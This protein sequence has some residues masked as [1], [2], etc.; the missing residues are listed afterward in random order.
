MR[1][2]V[3]QSSYQGSESM[4]KGLDTDLP[5]PGAFTS[6]HT[7]ENRFIRKDTAKEEIDSCVKEGFDFYLNFLWG[8]L[9][10]DV[11]G[12]QASQYFESLGVPSAGIRSWER[13]R[14][15]ND[16]YKEARKRGAPRVPGTDRF[17]LFVK[18][19]NGC[20]SQMIDERSVCHDEGELREALRRIN[21]ELYESRLNRGRSLGVPDF[22]AYA[23]G[24]DPVTRSEDIV[25]QEYI[26]GKE[27]IVSVIE[28]GDSAV[29]LNPC[30]V[31]TKGLS[32]NEKFLTFDLKFDSETRFELIE[33]KDNPALYDRLQTTA[34][35][36]F[37]TG[38]FHGSHMGCDVD[39]RVRPDG[40]VFAIE[41]NPQPAAF[42]V[43]CNF[44]DLPIISSFPGGHQAV[45]NV[46]IANYMLQNNHSI[47]SK[48]AATYDG[49]A[50][51]YD[52]LQSGTR[53]PQIVRGIVE[54]FDFQ[55][56]IFDLACGTGIF[57]RLLSECKPGS[58]RRAHT[59]SLVGF[60]I[61][62]M[63]VETCRSTGIYDAVYIDR[64]QTCLLNNLD[65]GDV[66]HIVCL[67]AIHFL[68]PEE[69]TF[70]LV[71][72]FLMA[73]KSITI[74]VDEIPDGY[75]ESLQALGHHHMYSTNHVANMEL[76]GEPRG[77]RL[78]TR[79]REFA[80]K[81]FTTQHE[82]WTTYYRFEKVG[83]DDCGTKLLEP[84]RKV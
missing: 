22:K 32:A 10:D 44:Q 4:L 35:E 46:F 75:N 64:M 42:L 77:W 48:V 28:L 1:I 16:F 81:S 60:D 15:K 36:A 74:G 49:L 14:T 30:I 65:Y 61:S 25:V 59:G 66:D 58:H 62:S 50:S 12:I 24:F 69:F 80:W 17:P 3:L 79:H 43:N 73:H 70:V 37:K 23:D 83:N 19:A 29:A 7:F 45:I 63:M 47:S 71:L 82:V 9:D 27:Y 13:S 52:N 18:P 5:N 76:F 21:V 2:C 54:K 34:L 40:E 78:A 26:P 67:S 51:D 11:A 38:M 31:K 8:T 84:K 41:V 20:A 33:K 68:S 72:C 55:G 39:L 6:Q 53:M 57:G 56:N